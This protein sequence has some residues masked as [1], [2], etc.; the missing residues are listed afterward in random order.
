MSVESDMN[1]QLDAAPAPVMM[2]LFRNKN[3][4]KM[5]NLQVKQFFLRFSFEFPNI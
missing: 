2:L 3:M 5:A 1:Q 4:I